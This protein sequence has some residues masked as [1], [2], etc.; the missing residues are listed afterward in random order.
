MSTHQ[1]TLEWIRKLGYDGNFPE[2]FDKICNSSTSF[3]WDQLIHNVKSKIEVD[4]IRNNILVNHLKQKGVNENQTDK[5]QC[6]PKEINLYLKKRKLEQTIENMNYSIAG[7]QTIKQNLIKQNSIKQFTIEKT[8]LRIKENE[9]QEFLLRE[10]MKMLDKYV[11]EAEDIYNLSMVCTPSE[12]METH[13]S[14]DIT[15]TLQQCKEMLKDS[16]KQLPLS[17]RN[18]SSG[19]MYKPLP[20]AQKTAK[21]NNTFENYFCMT[22][23]KTANK[24]KNHIPKTRVASTPK[25]SI[26]LF[27]EDGYKMKTRQNKLIDL[28][29]R[30]ESLEMY[31]ED[32]DDEN[33]L[34]DLNKASFVSTLPDFKHSFSRFTTI[35]DM[36]GSNTINSEVSNETLLKMIHKDSVGSEITHLLHKYSRPSIWN[37]FKFL[38]D[39]IHFDISKK[40]NFQEIKMS[41]DDKKKSVELLK[42]QTLHVATELK[43]IKSNFVLKLLIDKFNK[44]NESFY[45]SLHHKGYSQD[46]VDSLQKKLQLH[47]EN[48]GLDSLLAEMKREINDTQNSS[49]SDIHELNKSL[50]C[51]KEEVTTKINDLTSYLT[52]I[53]EIFTGIHRIR[54]N[55]INCVREVA[56]FTNDLNWCDPLQD[57]INSNELK[58][59]ERFPLEY[60]R[61]FINTDPT[62]NYRDYD[63]DKYLLNQGIDNEKLDMLSSI[64]GSP[65][66]P[67]EK[68]IHNILCSK[69]KFNILKNMT[70][71]ANRTP[72]KIYSLKELRSK[73]CT[74]EAAEQLNKL[75]FSSTS[76]KTLLAADVSTKVMNMW[77]EMHFGQFISPKIKVDGQDYQHFEKIYESYLS[78]L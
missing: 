3:I 31:V 53:Q 22:E 42:L 45:A 47:I 34:V 63:T 72:S 54:N 60:N 75:I 74:L 2:N 38:D 48:V 18:I 8:N 23:K 10:K 27:P 32:N 68:V 12:I 33:F 61:K 46:L 39:N 50:R 26:R 57:N 21:K 52:L 64:L 30:R 41:S 78:R 14:N 36:S 49:F 15:H 59:F 37:I 77:S 9:E 71:V 56:P 73:E 35:Q 69:M 44:K 67:P 43:L 16:I 20:S 1:E 62:L 51:I 5:S 19:A 55:S 40:M 58:I 13:S 66:S 70:S 65:F 25:V 76:N 28:S 17:G 29:T 7:K 4:N 24:I 6:F 11:E